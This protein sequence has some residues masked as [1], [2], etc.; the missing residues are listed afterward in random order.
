MPR[1]QTSSGPVIRAVVFDIGGVLEPPFDD[2]LI[3]ELAALIGIPT[4]HL[5][6]RRAAVAAAL[7]DGRLTLHDFYARLL[8]DGGHPVDAPRV[9]ARHLEVYEA[10][11]APLDVRVLA[12]LERLRP[13]HIVAC[14]TNTE[15]EVARFNRE[16]GLYRPFDR[17]YLSTDL[18]LHK[19]DRAIFE[20]ALRDLGCPA[21]ETA[22]TDDKAENVAGARAAGIHGIHYQDFEEFAHELDRLVGPGPDRP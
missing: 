5:A 22:F 1:G 13:R 9:V 15:I 18:G 17:A 4:A 8:A 14:L 10:T 11:A 3:P 6:A 19:P 2:V 21:K 12:L 7:S 16:R 20:H